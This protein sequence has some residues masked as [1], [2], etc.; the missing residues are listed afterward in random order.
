MAAEYRSRAS[1]S[2]DDRVLIWSDL[3]STKSHDVGFSFYTFPFL[4][5][6]I[7]QNAVQSARLGAAER[8]LDG[9]DR[10]ETPA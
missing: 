6:E 9:K 5:R 8:T 4:A 1:L 10:S 3:S 7:F 2:T